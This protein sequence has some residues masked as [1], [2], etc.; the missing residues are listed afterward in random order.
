MCGYHG[1]KA[2][3]GHKFSAVSVIALTLFLI[4]DGYIFPYGI[5][6]ELLGGALQAGCFVI[7]HLIFF[8]LIVF[9]FVGG[10]RKIRR[11]D[12][13]GYQ[14]VYLGNGLLHSFFA[15]H[16]SAAG[17]TEPDLGRMLVGILVAVLPFTAVLLLY[18]LESMWSR[19]RY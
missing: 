16:V 19:K 8:G 3:K 14:L 10:I 17:V 6:G 13:Q 15:L 1:E 4:L 5:L 9:L 11:F 18:R 2:E 7:F 12:R